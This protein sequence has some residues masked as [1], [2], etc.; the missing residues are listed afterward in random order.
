MVRLIACFQYFTVPRL[1]A[2]TP[3]E[4]GGLS[5]LNVLALE[6]NRLLDPA[7]ALCYKRRSTVIVNGTSSS[8]QPALS[9]AS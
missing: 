5:G 9:P 1:S 8:Y 4:T 2:S 3:M 7:N 6:K